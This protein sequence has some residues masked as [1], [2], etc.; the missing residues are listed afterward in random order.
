MKTH[1]TSIHLLDTS[2][3]SSRGKWRIA[4]CAL[5]LTLG[6]IT[7]F[8][9]AGSQ[10][11]AQ[12]AGA[13]Q[14]APPDTAKQLD[15]IQKHI[16]QLESELAASLAQLKAQLA[17][18]KDKDKDKD[19]PAP[20]IAAAAPAVPASTETPQK[21]TASVSPTPAAPASQAA[22]PQATTQQAGTTQPAGTN[23]SPYANSGTFW[24][25]WLK[26]DK[27]SHSVPVNTA[28]LGT[29]PSSAFDIRAKDALDADTPFPASA[30]D[31][32]AQAPAAGA[33]PAAPAGPPPVDLQTPFAFGDFTWM[34]SNPRNHDE[35]LDGKYFSGEF[36]VDTNYMWDYNHPIDDTLDETTEGE[37]TGEFVIQALG[38]G[39][40]FHA[41]NM[42]GR[43]LTQFGAVST[44]VPRND[45]SYSKG[46]WDLA[47]AYRY[48]TEMWAGYH[49]DVQHG[50]NFQVGD[51]L[52]Y[53]GL[54]SYYS[55]DNWIY[56]PS[57]VSSNTPWFFTG[58]RAQWF[59]TNK[60]KIEP[61]LINGWQTYAKYNGRE[62]FGGQ[63]LWRPTQNLDFVWNTYTLGRDTL[64]NPYR[65]RY[66]EDDS[67][68]WKYYDHPDRLI[69]KMAFTVTEDVGCETGGEKQNPMNVGGT[70]VVC[71]HGNTAT[72]PPSQN[73]MGI[74]AYHRWWIGKNDKFS[75]NIG[76][77]V[78]DN[79]GRYLALLPPI[80]G[81]NATS[82]TPYFPE[83]PGLPFRGYDY[84]VAFE[85]M[86]SQ[87][88]TWHV[89]FTQRGSDVPLFAGPGGM[90]PPGG[91]NGSPANYTCSTGVTSGYGFGALGQ[92]Q[93]ACASSGNGGIWYPDLVKQERR[94]I[95]ALMVKL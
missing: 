55:F 48:L 49:I 81:A 95:F 71:T 36:R 90:T 42:Q 33:A 13:A 84:Q 51:F 79:P 54:F 37:R 25:R 22:I 26:G 1:S 65:S 38:V 15:A 82:G 28:S 53:I 91:N 92:A 6:Q 16:E 14:P 21:T 88:V 20:A 2:Q 17:S 77:G 86:P 60:L 11:P 74:M 32:A 56:Q 69:N 80:N 4:S 18:D 43:I 47:D 61:W 27:A 58:M 34:L 89:E 50:L 94:W 3:R 66:H 8:A 70:N 5:V 52:S 29:P 87:W 31:A 57:Y 75:F 12:P 46:Q 62:G 68:E 78:V 73:F 63:I 76:G 59:P 83:N 23:L 44:A 93:A 39:G 45:A 72:R 85:Y 19:K 64:G 40:D 67:Q 10:T 41:G 30:Q 9:Q 35:V 7:C 24:K